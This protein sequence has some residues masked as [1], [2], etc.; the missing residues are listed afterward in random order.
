M[1]VDDDF[2]T[3]RAP[4]REDR[5]RLAAIFRADSALERA[6]GVRSLLVHVLAIVALPVWLA[7]V[8]PRGISSSLREAALGG[9][10]VGLAVVLLALGREAWCRRQRALGMATLPPVVL[11]RRPGACA[12]GPEEES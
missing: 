1:A 9:W 6:R 2:L 7:A 10:G 12:G 3:L 5:A 11:K 4:R 8:W